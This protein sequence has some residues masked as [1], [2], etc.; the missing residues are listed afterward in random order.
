MRWI[1]FPFVRIVFFFIAGIL[2]GLH[3]KALFPEGLAPI[4]LLVLV[5]VY[6][7][8]SAIAPN[9]WKIMRGTLG[10][11]AIFVGG[12]VH[13]IQQTESFHND[14]ILNLKSPIDFYTAALTKPC[15]PRENSWRVEARLRRVCIR[16]VWQNAEAKILLYLPLKEFLSPYQYGDVLLIKGMPQLVQGPVNPGE[17]DN[18]RFLAFRNIYHYQFLKTKTVKQLRHETGAIFLYWSFEAR[19]WANAIL[20]KYISGD[21]E[22]SIAAALVLGVNEGLDDELLSAYSSSGT[23]HVLSVSGLHVGIVYLILLF[24]LKPLK[25]TKSGRWVLAVLTVLILWIYAF[26]TGLSPSVLRAVTMFTLVALSEPLGQ[27][28][29]IY[30]T[31]AVSAFLLLLFDPFLIM[32]VGFQLSYLAVLGI[33]YLQPDLYKLW[34]P[35]NRLWDEVWKVTSVSL[36]AQLA[37][38]SLGLLYFHQFPN[39]FLISNLVIIPLSF[40]VLISG[41][42]LL[43]LSF[44]PMVASGIGIGLY[45]AIKVMNKIVLA[46]E[47]L[48]FS[49]LENVYITTMQGLLLMAIVILTILVV[50][51]RKPAYA[52][53]CLG[54][55]LCFAAIQ[56]ICFSTYF[57][58]DK[59]TVYNIPRHSAIDFFDNGQ[60]YF[61]T[62]SV[63]FKNT[64]KVRL[65]IQPNRMLHGI[66]DIKKG[67][68]QP[69]VRDLSGCTLM[70]WR[71]KYTLH[72]TDKNF[73][74]PEMMKLDYLL[75]GNNAVT[76]LISVTQQLHIEK[77]IID[78]SNSF[79]FADNLLKQA[80]TLKIDAY[81]VLH[82]G[83]FV[84]T[85]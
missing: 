51:Y 21:R 23:L 40:V 72:I 52:F 63:L 1:P 3:T 76:D 83:A 82:Q 49:R 47:L 74:L 28:S 64:K 70:L 39:Y 34:E 80:R 42:S 6:L 8:V 14:H 27:R 55:F 71:G 84:D 37:T 18:K 10:L 38:F 17:F 32:S 85:L 73:L 4:I 29:N 36:A 78:S 30:N 60:A 5:V 66:I 19:A 53:F 12:Y 16:G 11:F 48:P 61:F 24:F 69:F 20:K 65:H 57:N 35:R 58:V 41:L 67:E 59:I 68:D 25:K 7:L 56:W 9:Q 77:L 81:S 75:I 50:K 62:D 13:L 54:L 15:E 79:Y 33:V 45:W 46:I 44:I 31:L 2:A 43:A 26:I 22:H